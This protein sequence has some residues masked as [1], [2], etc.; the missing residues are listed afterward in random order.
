ML[1]IMC[2]LDLAHFTDAQEPVFVMRLHHYIQMCHNNEISLPMQVEKLKRPDCDGLDHLTFWNA[3]ICLRENRSDVSSLHT[4]CTGLGVRILGSG[5]LDGE[6]LLSSLC[7]HNCFSC[8]SR[9]SD[10]HPLDEHLFEENLLQ[11][12]NELLDKTLLTEFVKELPC[13]TNK[14]VDIGLVESP[15]QHTCL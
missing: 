7:Y 15:F 6:L 4:I 8:S 2:L 10:S 11:P 5:T 1:L 14:I 13:F 12:L 3:S 9:H